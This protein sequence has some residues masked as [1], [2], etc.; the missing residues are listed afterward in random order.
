MA[1][2]GEWITRGFEA[3]RRGT[4]ENAGQNIY[5]SRA[6]LLQ[7]IHLFDL[8][9]D[10]YVDLL[11]CN[12]QEDWEEPPAYV[13]PNPLSDANKRIELY[14]EGAVT[15]A[16]ADLNGDG[17]DDLV[18]GMQR[19]GRTSFELNA[20]IYYGSPEGLTERYCRLLPA[21]KCT[22][23]AV[24]DFN[25]D[26]RPD[27]A[28][29]VADPDGQKL[30]VFYQ[31]ELGFEPKRF[32]DLDLVVGQL[33]A[34]D[35]DGDGFADLYAICDDGPPRVFW[36]GPDGI[37]PS[38]CSE[39]V[40][41]ASSDKAT[42]VETAEVSEEE[43]VLPVGPL[44]RAVQLDGVWHLFVSFS[45][46]ACLVPVSRDRSFGDELR[47]ACPRAMSVAAGD[48]NGD[49][50]ADLVFAARD[51]RD[52]QERSWIYWGGADGFSEERRTVLNTVRACDVAVG[53]LGGDGC[54][55]I[56][57]CRNET[58]ETRERHS[59][60][61][62]SY[63]FRGNREGNIG[64]PIPL[65]TE[66]ARRVFM[67]KTSAG[68]RPEVIF[69]NQK[70]RGGRGQLDSVIYFGGPDGFSPDRRQEL[71]GIGPVSAVACDVNDDGYPDVIVANGAENAMGMD[72]GSYCFLGGPQG[73]SR[74]PS[75][76]IP[77]RL[78]WEMAVADINRDGY[79]DL[80]VAPFLGDLYIFYGSAS[81][82]DMDHPHRIHM[83]QDGI[84]YQSAYG[85]YL[86]DL[87][88]DGW[89]DLVVGQFFQ[90]TADN[91]RAEH[92][93]RCFILWGGPEGFDFK[94]HQTLSVWK[95]RVAT[96]A[97]L[98]GNGYLDLIIASHRRSES[99]PHDGFA[100]IYW[101]GP[102]GIREDRRQQL[103]TQTVNSMAVADFN[104]DGYL[105]L[106]V[107]SYHDG[108]F[109]DVDSYIYWG[110][111]GGG[112]SP[113]NFTRLGTHSASGCI[114]ADFNEDGW[115]DLA[116]ANHKTFGDH[117]G[118]SFVYWNGPDGFDC[119]RITRLP[120]CGVHGM[121][122]V[123][124]GNPRDRGPEEYYISEPFQLPEDARVRQISWEAELGPKTWVRAQLRTSS[125]REGLTSSP[126]R[127]PGGKDGWFDSGDL[128]E[129]VT[130]EGP[131]IQYRL[132]LGA[133]N[134]GCTP[135]V[136]EV[137]VKYG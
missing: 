129:A 69:V 92:G 115:I 24:G 47:F 122:Q 52:G 79:L 48:V 54:D 18:L 132:A 131:W 57:I 30:R 49:G 60:S 76:C 14:A 41:D 98:T 89:L 126:W 83:E 68:G 45:A 114:A 51:R 94:R 110:G 96:A 22:S 137:R 74:E 100:H 8:N 116:V 95:G 63:L 31:T 70:A 61:T 99:G 19:S 86:A 15:G 125:S 111:P 25:G 66:G 82:F 135:R 123:Q 5:V 134:S 105:D 97:D 3:F 130:P 108:R 77:T 72:P 120:T 43:Q 133:A 91:P 53:D 11:F 32:V 71:L 50:Y 104:N 103:I 16:V 121:M 112:F 13:Y 36:G 62:E 84:V 67:G 55:D 136:R 59:F 29:V 46:S 101:N 58:D 87:N 81:G 65:P 26:G 128:T 44:A 80:V 75:L 2:S 127:G 78:A 21:P 6:G 118:D 23:I 7:R 33:G 28:M 64:Q 37:D 109:R 106:F 56:V 38:R 27:I 42:V 9:R 93:D 12:S 34:V 10:G 20:F 17:Y 107:G 85:V 88:N 90:G 1:E 119:Q 102:E 73:F 113:R 117:K 40:V 39:I 35:L 124:P 4:F